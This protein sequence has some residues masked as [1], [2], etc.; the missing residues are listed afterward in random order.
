M[1]AKYLNFTI[2][3]RIAEAVSLL[4]KKKK[5]RPRRFISEMPELVRHLTDGT[6]LS[7][8]LVPVPFLPRTGTANTHAQNVPRAD[9]SRRYRNSIVNLELPS[10]RKR[11]L[12]QTKATTPTHRYMERYRRRGRDSNTPGT[13]SLRLGRCH[14]GH[15]TTSDSAA[16]THK[17]VTLDLLS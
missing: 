6:H 1:K 17:R 11:Q 3:R 12:T 8:Y 2:R 4:S 5:L 13:A 7:C 14:A 16:E 10:N 15:A 9:R